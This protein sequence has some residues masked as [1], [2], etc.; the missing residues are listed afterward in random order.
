ML[1]DH[2]LLI[3]HLLKHLYKNKLDKACFPRCAIYSDSKNLAKR[4]IS[5]TILKGRAYE[6]A[7]NRKYYGYQRAI[8]R[9]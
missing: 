9:L 1:V 5:D 7:R 3:Y 4:I 6:I 2:L 8:A